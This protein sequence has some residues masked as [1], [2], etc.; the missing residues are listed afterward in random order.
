VKR[1]VVGLIFSL[2]FTGEMV[3]GK[4]GAFEQFKD[5]DGRERVNSSSHSDHK[6]PLVTTRLWKLLMRRRKLAR[7]F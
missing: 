5:Q 4:H 1:K 3:Q 6:R 7:K 2:I